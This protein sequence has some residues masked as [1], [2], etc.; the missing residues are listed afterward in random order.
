MRIQSSLSPSLLFSS[1][2]LTGLASATGSFDCR[3]IIAEGNKYDL[4][5]LHGVHTIYHVDKAED[6]IV[7]T[8]YVLDICKTLGKAS[9]RGDLKCGTSKN[10][11][12][13]QYKYTEDRL[14][15]ISHAFPIAGLDPLGHGSKDAEVTRLKGDGQEG[16]LVKLAGGEYVDKD[17][18]KKDARAVIE[19]QC[20]PGRSG[21]EGLTSVANGSSEEEEEEEEDETRR[22]LMV[23]EDEGDKNKDKDK[24]KT[25][26]YDGSDPSRSLQFESFG[27]ADDDG[28][29]LKLK[30]RTRYAC[31][32]YV[33]DRKGDGSSHWGFFTWLIIILFLCVAAYLIFGSWLNYSRYGARGWDL[34]PH[35]DTLRDI[36]YIFQDWLRRVINTLQGSGSRG[37]YSA[38]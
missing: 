21:L 8:T 7:N 17:K 38:V 33:R 6:Y 36:P 19:F 9:I 13:F 14:E 22:R 35:G 27:P 28:Y 2:L 30:W 20:D 29:V 18:K 25:D 34:L 5:G 16:L 1:A 31:D 37:G 10:I 26:P 15:E 32:N 4:Y 12:G 24:E 11:C 3:N 23:R